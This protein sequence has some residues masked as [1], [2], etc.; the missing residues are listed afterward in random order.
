LDGQPVNAVVVAQPVNTTAAQSGITQPQAAATLVT[1]TSTVPPSGREDVAYNFQLQA[2]GGTAR[3]TWAPAM[4][5]T[6]LPT[7][8][9]L[10]TTGLIS[11]IPKRGSFPFTVIATDSSSPKQTAIQ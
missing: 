6:P 8:P 3:Y 11:G 7:T 5:S 1:I 4:N 10:S 2:S 9:T